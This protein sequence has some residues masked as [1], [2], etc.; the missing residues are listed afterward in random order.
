M[1]NLAKLSPHFALAALFM[2]TGK[3]SF[4]DFV[5]K[6]SSHLLIIPFI[7]G[8]AQWMYMN[9]HFTRMTLYYDLYKLGNNEN[10]V[11]AYT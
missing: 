5:G 2:A 11:A 9:R 1:M 7:T 4:I 10:H 6:A 8:G 3:F